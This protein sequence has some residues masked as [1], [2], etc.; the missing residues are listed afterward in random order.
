MQKFWGQNTNIFNE[1]VQRNYA[2]TK[3]KKKWSWLRSKAFWTS[4]EGGDPSSYTS[5][6]PNS[7]SNSNSLLSFTFCILFAFLQSLHHLAAHSSLCFCVSSPFH[8]F[9]L[10][11]YVVLLKFSFSSR[12]KD[13]FW[14]PAFP[15]FLFLRFFPPLLPFINEFPDLKW[16]AVVF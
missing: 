11:M 4:T 2:G 9:Q 12:N 15:F 3:K 8:G 14:T 13:L 7:N 16:V 10:P 1:W 6:P 5:L